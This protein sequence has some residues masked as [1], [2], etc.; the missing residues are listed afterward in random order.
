MVADEKLSLPCSGSALAS[1][2]ALCQNVKPVSPD[3]L[4]GPWLSCGVRRT[5]RLSGAVMKVGIAKST[6][7][8]INELG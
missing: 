8:L 7:T 1:A 6:L 2:D 3:D 5:M 4:Q